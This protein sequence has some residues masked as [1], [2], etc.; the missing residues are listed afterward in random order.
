MPAGNKV[1]DCND[2]VRF[3]EKLVASPPNDGTHAKHPEEGKKALCDN[4]PD[5][6][7]LGDELGV[8]LG[9]RLVELSFDDGPTNGVDEGLNKNDAACPSVQE[10]EVFIMNSCQKAQYGVAGAKANRER[11]QSKSESPH[12]IVE[13]T[14]T[15]TGIVIRCIFDRSHPRLVDDADET[16]SFILMDA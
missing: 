3:A 15:R 14:Q 11:G 12:T 2:K 10:V 13:S 1:Q 7:F 5:H 8:H 16:G 6:V 4:S 9:L